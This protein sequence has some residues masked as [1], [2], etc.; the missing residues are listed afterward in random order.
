MPTRHVLVMFDTCAG[1]VR[2]YTIVNLRYIVTYDHG[3]AVS[4]INA[5]SFIGRTCQTDEDN[6]YHFIS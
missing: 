6:K 2:V 1:I 5:I 4:K 3:S